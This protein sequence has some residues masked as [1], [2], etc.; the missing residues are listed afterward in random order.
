MWWKCLLFAEIFIAFGLLFRWMRK[1]KS[2]YNALYLAYENLENAA[3]KRVKENQSRKLSF[4]QKKGIMYRLEQMLIYSGLSKKVSVITPELYIAINLILTA[5]IYI[6]FTILSGS[7]WM[8]LIAIAVVQ[9][10]IYFLINRRMVHN[11]NAVDG[12]LLKFLDFLGNYSITSGEITNILNQISGYMSEPLKTVLEECYYEAQTS[13][14]TGLALSNMAEKIQHPK[15]KELVVNLEISMRYSADFT[16][17][18]SQSR[19]SIREHMRMRIEQKAL[20]G[21]AW[22]NIIILGAMTVVI[23][24]S[25]G[26]LI[27][28]SF[29]ELIAGNLVGRVCM[30]G[31]GILLFLFYLQIRKLDE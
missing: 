25:V 1:G 12:E 2:L 14:D 20:A 26:V 27:G 24:K 17:L 29:I 11:F 23:F 31:I 22:I 6:A 9:I 7:G 28:M 21:E 15:F 8:G 18:V 5:I 30:L 19:K 4:S 16:V 10:V 13:G 3:E